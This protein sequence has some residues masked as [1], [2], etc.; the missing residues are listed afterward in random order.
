MPHES[1]SIVDINRLVEDVSKRF[2]SIG[3]NLRVIVNLDG[4]IPEVRTNGARLTRL[5]S[6]AARALLPTRRPPARLTFRTDR[7]TSMVVAISICGHPDSDVTVDPRL[8][9]SVAELDISS[10]DQ[11]SRIVV[12][13]PLQH[14]ATPPQDVPARGKTI[15][16]VDDESLFLT[17]QSRLLRMNGFNIIAAESGERALNA[18]RLFRDKLEWAIID[19][20]M[21]NMPGTVLF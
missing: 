8:A 12:R 19:L 7:D 21:P 4:T 18:A 10:D 6:S 13:V 9:E 16:L 11:K 1:D 2:A 15:L 20:C 3:S 14:Q 5:L 17:A